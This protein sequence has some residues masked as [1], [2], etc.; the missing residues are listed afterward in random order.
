MAFLDASRSP[1]G[2]AGTAGATTVPPASVPLSFLVAAGIGL[3]A[4]GFA[5]ALAADHAVRSPVIPGVV[6]AVH[7]GVL[8]FLTMAVL[9]AVHQFAPVVGRRPLRSIAVARLTLVGILGAAW[10]LPTGFAHGPS[11]LVIVGGLFGAVG[12]AAAAWNLSGPLSGDG[13]VPVIGLRLSVTYLVATV[14]FGVVYAFDRQ[15]G[16]FPLLSHRVLA[17]AHL[18]LLGW[19][20]LTYVAVAEKL[21]PMFLLAHRPRARSGAWAVGLLACGTVVLATG[22]LFAIPALAWPGGVAVGAGLISHLVSLVGAV[23]HRRRPLELLHAYLA[24]STAFLLAAM[25]FAPVAA[26]ADVDSAVRARL[27]SAEVLCLMAWLTLAIVGHAHK[28]VPF[29]TYS[30]MRA[31][32][33]TRGPSGKPLLFGDLFSAAWARVALVTASAGF[34]AAVAGLAAATPTAVT[35]GGFG[36][37][38]TGL[39]ATLNLGLGPR[40]VTRSVTDTPA[41]AAGVT[42]GAPASVGTARPQDRRPA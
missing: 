13:G 14:T 29:I 39:V 33:V 2:P 30:A 6:S 35:V 10:L 4:F 8:A 40:R 26:L 20:G 17:H 23:R 34:A 12:V 37:A 15:T 38:A 25:V 36:V 16:W 9:G 19:L 11:S 27:V 28:I 7:V 24:A 42:T 41:T 1:A 22:L 3:T 31:R 21:W 18:G 32:G 5:M